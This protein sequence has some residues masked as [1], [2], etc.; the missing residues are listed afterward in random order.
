[1]VKQ[2]H[3]THHA[4][5]GEAEDA[6]YAALA[7]GDVNALMALWA[8]DEEVVCVHPGGA[9]LVGV[10]AIRESYAQI[11]ANGP[12]RVAV[13]ELRIQSGVMVAVHSLVE[14]IEIGT[15]R[16]PS[17]IAQVV[18]TNVYMKGPDGWQIVLHHASPGETL[19]RTLA[20]APDRPS[21]RLH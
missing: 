7:R 6:F 13:R 11:L 18:T 17:R 5:S 2:I 20:S 14:H 15:P 21:G 1:M 19:E 8:D 3:G 16:Q 4:S 12:L 9:R 10:R